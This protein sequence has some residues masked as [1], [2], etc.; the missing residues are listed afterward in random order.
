MAPI[1]TQLAIL[2]NA[3]DDSIYSAGRCPSLVEHSKVNQAILRSFLL[4][5]PA[6]ASHFGWTERI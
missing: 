2:R 5:L 1:T 4:G 3:L 6:T